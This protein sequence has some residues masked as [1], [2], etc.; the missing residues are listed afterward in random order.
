MVSI[1]RLVYPS[2]S[3]CLTGSL[4]NHL[5]RR[6]CCFYDFNTGHDCLFQRWGV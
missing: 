4:W 6:N 5:F 1:W 2:I 3:A